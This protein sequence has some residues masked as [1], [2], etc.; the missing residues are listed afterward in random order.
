MITFLI[1]DTCIIGYHIRK[2]K[3]RGKAMK[4]LRGS[5][6]YDGFFSYIGRNVEF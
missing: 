4:I 5:T 1:Y 6:K 3:E 2:R